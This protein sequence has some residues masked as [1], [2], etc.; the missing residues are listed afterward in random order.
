MDTEISYS[1]GLFYFMYV[2]ILP[3]CLCTTCL[4]GAAEVRRG[5]LIPWDWSTELLTDGANSAAQY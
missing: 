1:T 3:A 2:R 4:P 5:H